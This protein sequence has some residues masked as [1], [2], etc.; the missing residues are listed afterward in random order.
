MPKRML[1]LAT[2][3][4]GFLGAESAR[5][6]SGFGITVSY[7]RSLDAIADW[8]AHAEHKIAQEMGK[9]DWYIHYELHIAKV[10]RPYSKQH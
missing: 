5:T 7:W 1:A 9:S 8:K 3:Q 6:P 10:E 4:P 2:Q